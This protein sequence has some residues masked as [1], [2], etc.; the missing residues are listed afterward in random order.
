MFARWRSTVFFEITSVAAIS[1][2]VF[3]SAISLTTSCSRGVSGS[4]GTVSPLRARSRWSRISA[5]TAAGY[6]NGSPRIAAR[7]ASTR[8]RLAADFRT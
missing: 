1:S 2:L 5:V 3:P 4:S 8:S 6:R 7:I